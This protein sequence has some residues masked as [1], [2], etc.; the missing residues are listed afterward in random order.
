MQLRG[1]IET[2]RERE[3]KSINSAWSGPANVKFL[4]EKMLKSHALC[5]ELHWEQEIFKWRKLVVLLKNTKKTPHKITAI[6]HSATKVLEQCEQVN[7]VLNCIT[8]L[9]HMYADYLFLNCIIIL[10]YQSLPWRNTKSWKRER[11]KESESESKREREQ[12]P[13]RKNKMKSPSKYLA[14]LVDLHWPW[15]NLAGSNPKVVD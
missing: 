8:S 10:W 12:F 3:K 11:E 4:K 14:S 5:S 6:S 9:M 15:K 2:E 1:A 13:H 7:N